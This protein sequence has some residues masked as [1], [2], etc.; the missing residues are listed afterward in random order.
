M[1]D[2]LNCVNC[3]FVSPVLSFQNIISISSLLSGERIYFHIP[4]FG[5]M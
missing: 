4:N 2:V 3:N 5:S 1:K